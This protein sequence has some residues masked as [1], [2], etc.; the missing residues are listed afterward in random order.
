MIWVIVFATALAIVF[1]L[2]LAFASK[3]MDPGLSPLVSKIKDALPDKNCGGCG[4]ANCEEY[5]KALAKD[6]SLVGKCVLADEKMNKKL[7]EI[8][9]GDAE[10]VEKKKAKVFCRGGSREN[11]EYR[12]IESCKAAK[13]NR[14]ESKPKNW[15]SC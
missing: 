12:G 9:G 11:A 14:C 1:G 6:S 5:A 3:K 2:I 13:I 10:G 4:Y 15:A 8:T 7:S